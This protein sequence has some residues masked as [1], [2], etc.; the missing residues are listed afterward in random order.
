MGHPLDTNGENRKNA[1]DALGGS[2]IVAPKPD[3][4]AE[5]SRLPPRARAR[6]KVSLLPVLSVFPFS[7]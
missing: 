5:G 2:P 7:P 6:F 3:M 4:A 1:V